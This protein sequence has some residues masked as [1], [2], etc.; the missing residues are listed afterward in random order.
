MKELKDDI[1]KNSFRTCYLFYGPEDYMKRAYAKKIKGVLAPAEVEM[2]N[3]DR[4]EGKKTLAEPIISAAETMP[5][6][7]EKRL[8]IVQNAGFFQAGKKAESERLADYIQKIPDTTCILFLEN[9]IDKRSR[10]YKAISKYGY[11]VE[12]KVQDEKS[13][14]IWISREVKKRGCTIE[15]NISAYLLRT[16][17]SDMEAIEKEVEKLVT[18]KK[19]GEE[20]Q[21]EDIEA[22]CTKSL[23][24]RIFDLVAAIGNQKPETAVIIYRNMLL[25]KESPIMVLSM[26]V[27]QFRLIL[28]SKALLAEGMSSQAI[29]QR[30]GQR[31]FIIRDCIKQSGNFT[32][33][34]LQK[35]VNDC[36]A[37]DIAIKTG[38]MEA[39]MAVE[40]L[41]IEQGSIKA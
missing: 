26:I 17:G 24:A 1:K 20:I 25:M 27:R 16:V 8:I 6:L 35:A 28:Q 41:I 2:M 10:L 30:L 7:S 34:S 11:T 14:V 5:F 18:Y 9:D 39:E 38:K 36:L 23:E 21:R 32:L 22:V 33:K 31:D 13:L 19:Q 12:F 15:N 29:A 3:F 4:F 40:I 37:V